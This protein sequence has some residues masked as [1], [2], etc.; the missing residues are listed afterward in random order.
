[1]SKMKTVTTM[2]ARLTT[3][4]LLTAALSVSA[5][6]NRSGGGGKGY[7]GNATKVTFEG[8]YYRADLKRLKDDR[9]SFTVTVREVSQGLSGAKE[10]GR[11]EATKYCIS[12]YGNSAVNWQVG[13]DTADGQLTITDN[14]LTFAG[15]CRG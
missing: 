10:A 8:N 5:C 3:I 1:M 7:F 2:G 14:T 13:P 15:T 9:A 4:L 11:F 6:G 12:Q